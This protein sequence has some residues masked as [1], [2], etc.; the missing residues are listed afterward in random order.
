V[1]HLLYPSNLGVVTVRCSHSFRLSFGLCLPNEKCRHVFLIKFQNTGS[2]KKNQETYLQK[3][4]VKNTFSVDPNIL[5]FIR[6]SNER[7]TFPHFCE[8]CAGVDYPGMACCPALPPGLSPALI[9]SLIGLR[10]ELQ[11]PSWELPLILYVNT[12]TSAIT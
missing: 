1:T 3:V 5:Y 2:E 10:V 11:K 12:P 6:I 7:N 9:P 4:L 8:C